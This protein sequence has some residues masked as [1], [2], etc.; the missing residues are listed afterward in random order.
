MPLWKQRIRLI[1]FQ[2]SQLKD[3]EDANERKNVQGENM[4]TT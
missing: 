4:S 1:R 2:T 3:L